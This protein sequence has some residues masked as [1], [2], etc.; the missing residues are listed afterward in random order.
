MAA[1]IQAADAGL[2]N[3]RSVTAV[4]GHPITARLSTRRL[5]ALN[6]TAASYII[7]YAHFY[8]ASDRV[9]RQN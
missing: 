8:Y 1:V 3:G 6:S 9:R 2:E 5:F 4:L 7:Y